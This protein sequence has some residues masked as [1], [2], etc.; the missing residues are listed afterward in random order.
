M[1]RRLEPDLNVFRGARRQ[2]AQ[3]EKRRPRGRDDDARRARLQLRH[4][5]LAD[6]PRD[7]DPIRRRRRCHGGL[8]LLGRVEREEGNRLA[9]LLERDR[10][11]LELR[12]WRLGG[13]DQRAALADRLVGLLDADDRHRFASGDRRNTTPAAINSRTSRPASNRIMRTIEPQRR[14]RLTMLT[15][16]GSLTVRFAS[17]KMKGP[18]GRPRW[19]YRLTVRT[20]G[21]QPSNRGSIPRTATIQSHTDSPRHAIWTPHTLADGLC[22]HGAEARELFRNVQPDMG[23]A[24]WPNMNNGSH[25]RSTGGIFLLMA[26][27]GAL[28]GIVA[29]PAVLAGRWWIVAAL[30]APLGLMMWNLL[31]TYY[32]VSGDALSVRCLLIRKTVPLASV[33]ML[34]ASRDFRSSPALSLDR[35]EVLYG[36]D[37]VLVSPKEKTAFIRALRARK[38][39][40]AIEELPDIA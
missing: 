26:A 8:R 6:G 32:V 12:F 7:G 37:S 17:A 28:S 27:V 11:R 2:R 25:Q 36:N 35:I 13:D 34:R 22:D 30:V 16:V 15:A 20:D 5:L 31:S 9:V 29:V 3:V 19:R 4:A 38:P 1:R 40:I 39:S 18:V 23:G 24:L 33:T 21:S 10:Q 14:P